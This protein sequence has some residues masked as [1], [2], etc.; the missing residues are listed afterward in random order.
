MANPLARH[1]CS[2]ATQQCGVFALSRKGRGIFKPREL[3]ITSTWRRRLRLLQAV[4]PEFLALLAVQ[5]LLFGLLRALDRLGAV[6]PFCLLGRG[7]SRR[8]GR[9]RGGCLPRSRVGKKAAK[10]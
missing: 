3:T 6:R 8:G 2:N 1:K 4:G 9:G 5:A 7:C 10:Q